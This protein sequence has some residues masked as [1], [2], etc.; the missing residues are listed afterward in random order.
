VVERGSCA[1][2]HYD[3]EGR[4]LVILVAQRGGGVLLGILKQDWSTEPDQNYPGL[5]LDLS[6]VAY[7]NLRSIGVE[8][9][10]LRGH[11][12][13]LADTFLDHLA[14]TSHL[15]LI[16]GERRERIDVERMALTVD[17]LRQCRAE[18]T[19]D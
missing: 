18:T 12:F 8:V 3:Q 6:G 4:R 19:A 15:T 9:D 11:A 17:D 7:R 14:T 13:I 2:S 10:G 5:R 16:D 1:T